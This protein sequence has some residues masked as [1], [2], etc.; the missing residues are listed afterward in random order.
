MLPCTTSTLANQLRSLFVIGDCALNLLGTEYNIQR[1]R[2][3]LHF[4]PFAPYAF[5]PSTA[6]LIGLPTRLV[7]ILLSLLSLTSALLARTPSLNR[8]STGMVSLH[9]MHASVTDWP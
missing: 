1:E 3:A 2:S 8:S 4:D 7:S 6:S 5:T 9:E